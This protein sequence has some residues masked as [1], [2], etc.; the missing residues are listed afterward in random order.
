MSRR[1]ELSFSP[2]VE[3]LDEDRRITIEAP[4][5]ISFDDLLN[6]ITAAGHALKDAHQRWVPIRYDDVVASTGGGGGGGGKGGGYTVADLNAMKEAS[7]SGGVV[8]VGVGGGGGGGGARLTAAPYYFHGQDS[9]GAA[10]ET[11]AGVADGAGAIYSG[12]I[13]TFPDDEVFPDAELRSALV[14]VGIDPEVKLSRGLVAL[15]ASR[16]D[17]QRKLAGEAVD[18]RDGALAAL[19]EAEAEG[20]GWIAAKR[21]ALRTAH[22]KLGGAWAKS[23]SAAV[24]PYSRYKTGY[25]AGLT[26]AMNE[27]DAL[28]ADLGSADTEGTSTEG[29]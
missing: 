20:I 14:K 25:L 26:A 12:L 19:A 18:A 9:A 13:R 7:A 11:K 5:G 21:A 4:D 8:G 28:L 17:A 15:L 24:R 3:N 2:N 1:I 23:E 29:K 10:A 27:V 16:L 22:A 6:Q